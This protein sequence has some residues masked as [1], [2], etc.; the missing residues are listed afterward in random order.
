MRTICFVECPT[1]DEP[2]EPW[3]RVERY[4]MEGEFI[5][6][7]SQ[8]FGHGYPCAIH[9]MLF[10][11]FD[12]CNNL[13]HGVD[14]YLLMYPENGERALISRSEDAIAMMSNLMYAC[15]MGE[16]T[17]IYTKVADLD[18]LVLDIWKP[19]QPR[20]SSAPRIMVNVN[21]QQS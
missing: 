15:G 7:L 8:F 9:K 18:M 2:L 4:S 17:D 3:Q 20:T 11:M 6:Q 5:A 21:K 1:I 13:A 16:P 19:A 14:V 10:P 12:P